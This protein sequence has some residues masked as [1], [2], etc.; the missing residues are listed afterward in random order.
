MAIFAVCCI[1]PIMI[2]VLA[3]FVGAV[4]SSVQDSV[5]LAPLL[6][7]AAGVLAGVALL[8]TLLWGRSQIVGDTISSSAFR[9]VGLVLMVLSTGIMIAGGVGIFVTA[10]GLR[11]ALDALF[12]AGSLPITGVVGLIAGAVQV[13]VANR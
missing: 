11:G 1:L 3:F 10:F 4:R 12:A 5:A 9:T 7:G 13:S 6:M 2:S 8:I